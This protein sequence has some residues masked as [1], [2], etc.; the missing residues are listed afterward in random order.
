MDWNFL[1][2]MNDVIPIEINVDFKLFYTRNALFK[3]YIDICL[4]NCSR[5]MGTNGNKIGKTK[6][7]NYFNFYPRKCTF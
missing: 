3:D 6:I 5:K 1:G 2:V 4:N 7:Q